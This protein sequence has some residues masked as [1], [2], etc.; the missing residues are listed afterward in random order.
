MVPRH[1]RY[2]HLGVGHSDVVNRTAVGRALRAA[3]RSDTLMNLLPGHGFFD[4]GCR[5]LA[6]ALAEVIGERSQVVYVGRPGY[7]D[8]AV[9]R[10]RSPEGLVYLD[11]DGAA[12]EQD[13]KAKI[14][15]LE[16]HGIDARALRITR[17][18]REALA[19]SGVAGSAAISAEIVRHLKPR[20]RRA[21]VELPSRLA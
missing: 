17:P 4:G 18:G 12:S 5:Y 7:L 16:L 14:A 9:C 20:L 6:E 19:R 11:A 8:H 13:L 15:R 3:C 21:L 1:G 10:V 2:Q